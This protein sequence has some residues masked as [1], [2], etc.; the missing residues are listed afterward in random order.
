MVS[1]ILTVFI[2]ALYIEYL[3]KIETIS[4]GIPNEVKEKFSENV[5]IFDDDYYKG[6]IKKRAI[7]GHK[8]DYGKCVLVAGSLGFSGASYICTESCVKTGA[9]LTTL[10]TTEECQK[11]V[12]NQLIEA[13]TINYTELDRVKSVVKNANVIATDP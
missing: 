7:Y 8:G 2:S 1:L 9:G 11:I 13:M 3:G 10:I 12:S 6:L 5:Y 4:I